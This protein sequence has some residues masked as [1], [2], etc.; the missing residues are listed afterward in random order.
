MKEK[1]AKIGLNFEII[2]KKFPNI[3]EYEETVNA[4]LSDPFFKELE[5]MLDDE[6]Y[7]MA[8]DATKGLYILAS[9]LCI[10][11]LY[12]ALLEIFEDLEYEMYED[13]M[14]HYIDMM[15]TYEKIRG[16]FNA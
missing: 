13:V 8:K 2:S 11:P 3:D 7:A 5:G 6:D 12:E 16:A 9:D 4:Y 1:Y 10:Y 15:E 14:K